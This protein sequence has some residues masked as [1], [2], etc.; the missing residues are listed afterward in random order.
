MARSPVSSLNLLRTFEVAGRHLSFRDAAAELCVSP[1]AV[2]QHVRT[3]EEELGLPLFERIHRGLRFTEAGRQYWQSVHE[4]LTALQRSTE[5]VR[6]RGQRL[7]LRVSIMP[8]LA[9]RVVLPALDD[10]QE[11]HPDI[12]LRL[13]SSLRNVDL[14]AG[15]ADLAIRFGA[16]PWPGCESRKISDLYVLPVCPPAMAEKY[17]L[18]NH[19]ENLARM[20]LIHMTERPEAWPRFFRQT[21]LGPAE[22]AREYH[23]DDYP[24]AVDAAET[25]GV[26]LAVLPPE[27]P[28]LDS[29]RLAAPFPPMGPMDEAIH[30]VWPENSSLPGAIER[31]LA[32]LQPLIPAVPGQPFD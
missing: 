28:L 10:F 17:D 1:A 29:H 24:A 23:V 22:P 16:P 5:A 19:P 30:A 27:Q 32:W 2:S 15:D 21:G 20:P 31:F 3:L 11:K 6:R 13:D 25:L 7:L 14:R 8:P 9:S 18:K 4:H 26:A 12:E